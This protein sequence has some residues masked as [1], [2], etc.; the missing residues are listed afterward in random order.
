V[1]LDSGWSSDDV[2]EERI[3]RYATA[4]MSEVHL[5]HLGLLSSTG[6]QAAQRVVAACHRYP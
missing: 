6:L 3:T 1:R 2:V 4:G 5:Y